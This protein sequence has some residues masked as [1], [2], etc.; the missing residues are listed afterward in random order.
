[1]RRNLLLLA[2]LVLVVE[3]FKA[4]KDVLHSDQRIRKVL[5]KTHTRVRSYEF[6][7]SEK[8]CFS[9]GGARGSG[10]YIFVHSFQI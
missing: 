2:E 9:K 8:K 10:T 6:P 4:V 7:Q 5:Q 3:Q 1:M